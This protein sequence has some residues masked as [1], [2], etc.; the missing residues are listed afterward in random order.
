MLDEE[1]EAVLAKK[2]AKSSGSSSSAVA[3]DAF[4]EEDAEAL[5]SLLGSSRVS[6]ADATDK[7]SYAGSNPESGAVLD[8][9][10]Q[11]EESEDDEDDELPSSSDVLVE[12]PIKKSAHRTAKSKGGSS[13]VTQSTFSPGSGAVGLF[14]IPGNFTPEEIVDH[15]K[16]L[17]GNVEIRRIS[18]PECLLTPVPTV[19]RA[20]ML[21][22]PPGIPTGKTGIFKFGGIDL[23][24]RT[25][26]VQQPYGAPFYKDIMNQQWFDST[27]FEGMRVA[28]F[29]NFMNSPV[30]ILTLMTAAMENSLKEYTTGVRIKIKFTEEEFGPR[31]QHHQAA[32]LNLQARSPTWFAQFQRDLYSKIVSTSNF[33]HLKAMV[34]DSEEDELK[35]VDFDALEASATANETTA[36]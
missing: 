12:G 28:S 18:Q 13:R 27:K 14:G 36:V 10:K 32:L 1:E 35:G 6:A 4:G 15:I 19:G 22:Q 2:K 34:T 24:A 8:D 26:N 21:A 20:P 7:D 17:T 23:E 25:Y 30:P 11:M 33:P 9:G 5:D 16:W 29:Q 3:S 31:Y